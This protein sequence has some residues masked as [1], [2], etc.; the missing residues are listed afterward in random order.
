MYEFLFGNWDIIHF[1]LIKE[2]YIH[3]GAALCLQDLIQRLF[4]DANLDGHDG[5]VNTVHFN[6][7]GE[8]LV[9]GSDDRKIVFWD[10]SAQVQKLSYNSGHDNNVFQA[11][12]M[13]FSNNHSVVSCA[14]DGQVCQICFLISTEGVRINLQTQSM[15]LKMFIVMCSPFDGMIRLP[16][17]WCSLLPT[18]AAEVLPLDNDEWT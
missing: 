4:L 8:L 3:D 6:P 9:S 11:K 15:C 2:D 18:I 13:P 17:R 10:W 12:I 14:A 16:E 1:V 7:S 5:C